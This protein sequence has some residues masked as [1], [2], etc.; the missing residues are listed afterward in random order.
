MNV[1]DLLFWLFAAATCGGAIGVVLSQNVVRMA[2]WL[3]VSLGSVAGLF[4]LLSAD[5]LGAAQLLIYVGGTVVL[6]IFGVMLTASGPYLKLE[7][8]PTEVLL[9]LAA[10][11]GLLGVLVYSVGAVNW[12]T[13]AAKLP[14]PGPVSAV[15]GRTGEIVSSETGQSVKP[16]GLALLGVRADHPERPGYLLPFEVISVHLLIV[17]IGAGYLA[18]AKRR[19]ELVA[20]R[21]GE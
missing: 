13:V 11:V 1:A 3:M 12:R 10:G 18:R 15:A 7:T 8:R 20:D 5:F 2:F 14:E 4:F 9:G 16:L 21:D 6:L 17:L 19:V